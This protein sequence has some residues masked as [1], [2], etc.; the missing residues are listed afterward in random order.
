MKMLR[1]H[2]RGLVLGTLVV[3]GASIFMLVR[4]TVATYAQSRNDQAVARQFIGTWRLVSNPQRFADG[5][6]R[7]NPISMGY[8]IYTDTDRMCYVGMN[9]NRPKWKS[10]TAPSESEAVSGIN[11]L[12]AYCARVEIHASEGF[13]LHHVEIGRVPNDV[14]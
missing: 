3:A 6:T 14:G 1:A 12:Q 9:P 13:V 4:G 10:R 7:Q 8:I 5:T 2:Y 11:G